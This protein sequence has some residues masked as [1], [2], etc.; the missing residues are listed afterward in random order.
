MILFYVTF[1]TAPI[2]IIVAVR[3]WNS[4]PSMIH[5]TKTRYVVA[6]ILAALQVV[7][8]I[9]LVIALIGLFYAR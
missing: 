1:I 3:H 9:F 6:I 2:A 4:P 8:W 5:R 7:G